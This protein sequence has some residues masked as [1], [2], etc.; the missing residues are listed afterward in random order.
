MHIYRYTGMDSLSFTDRLFLC[1]SLAAVMVLAFPHLAAANTI[2]N[3]PLLAEID[4]GK[5][6]SIT[7]TPNQLLQNLQINPRVAVLRD[8]LQ[9]KGSPMAEHAEFLL[10][11]DHYQF[12][13][14]I[15]YAEGHM[16]RHQIRPNNCWG[17]G[18]GRP[19]SYETLPDGIVRAN[20]L[21]GKYQASGLN[22]PLKMRTRWVGWHNPTWPVAVDQVVGELKTRGL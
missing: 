19:E 7:E 4:G 16:C 20:E 12:V 11:Q 2:D 22:T 15:A 3:T 9:A 10:T 18:G 5:I 6:K 8:Y 21:I 13:I 17:I 1:I 14:A